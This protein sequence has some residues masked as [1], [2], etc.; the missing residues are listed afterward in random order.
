V[1]GA[2]GKKSAFKVTQEEI[3]PRLLSTYLSLPL[4]SSLLFSLSSGAT[5]ERRGI[6]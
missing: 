4:L 3:A 6:H 1:P 5:A 2:K